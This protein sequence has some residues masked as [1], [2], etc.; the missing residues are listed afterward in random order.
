MY[1]VKLGLVGCSVDLPPSVGTG[2][3]GRDESCSF[4]TSRLKRWVSPGSWENPSWD[5]G[6]GR[7]FSCPVFQAQPA[8]RRMEK[9]SSPCPAAFQV[10]RGSFFPLMPP[11]A[12]QRA[13][14]EAG[15]SLGRGQLHVYNIS[16]NSGSETLRL[17]AQA[18]LERQRSWS[19]SAR[20]S[21][22][23]QRDPSV[24]TRTCF[25]SGLGM[26]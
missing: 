14:C 17:G 18:M 16:I 8:L 11:S 26:M 1:H 25:G 9:C 21:P 6:C 10:A 3:L 5:A 4:C 13:L 23:C 20:L 19:T 22:T 15:V 7:L 12:E 24:E 2:Q